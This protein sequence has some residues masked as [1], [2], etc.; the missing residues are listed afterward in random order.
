MT[1]LSRSHGYRVVASD[2]AI[3]EVETPLFPPYGE[4][5]DFVVVR[6]DGPTERFA[7]VPAPLVA[8][9]EEIGR[10]VRLTASKETIAAL[11]EHVPIEP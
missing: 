11:P 4:E 10:T 1:P 5:P 9:V 2:G 3:G 7:V 6:V 8:E